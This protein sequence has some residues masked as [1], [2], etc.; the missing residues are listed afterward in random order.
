M[1][2]SAYFTSRAHRKRFP[3]HTTSR[4]YSEVAPLYGEI[5]VELRL[6]R[7]ENMTRNSVYTIPCSRV[8]NIKKKQAS[9]KSKAA[10][11]SK[12]RSEGERQ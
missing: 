9:S 7:G 6:T 2:P 12:S 10:G 1:P 11:T 8:K 5:F 3:V 4:Q